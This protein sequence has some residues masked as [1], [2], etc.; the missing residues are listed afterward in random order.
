M[1][2]PFLTVT[3]GAIG[4]AVAVSACGGVGSAGAA[5]SVSTSASGAASVSAAS[6]AGYK[7]IGGPAQGVSLE[8]PDSWAVIN[9]AQGETLQE[10]MKRL[11]VIGIS[12]A[13]LRQEL[14]GIQK[15]NAV[16]AIDLKSAANSPGHFATN[17]YAFCGSSGV[18]DTGSAGMTFLRHEEASGIRQYPVQHVSMTQTLVGGIP[19]LQ[20][21]LSYDAKV[22]GT[23]YTLDARQLV[24]LPKPGRVCSVTLTAPAGQIPGAVLTHART[25]V[26]FP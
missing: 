25:T 6:A 8:V 20:V 2:L 17:I 16:S 21:S 26:N 18:T 11:E 15:Q 7:R 10:A 22:A 19:G 4:L 13:A 5:R 9:F 12:Q 23:I 24:V 3:V 14:Q 1:K